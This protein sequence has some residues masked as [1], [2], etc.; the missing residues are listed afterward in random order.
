MCD[1]KQDTPTT[2]KLLSRT[3][4][5]RMPFIDSGQPPVGNLNVAR[6][7]ASSLA[8]SYGMTT[9]KP[10]E[11]KII[12]MRNGKQVGGIVKPHSR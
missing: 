11:V 2:Y 12:D 9:R 4:G 5:T 6:G 1:S 10:Q 3:A 8:G 7:A